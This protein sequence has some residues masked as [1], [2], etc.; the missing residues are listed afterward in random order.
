MFFR[1]HTN[2][3][4]H[5]SDDQVFVPA[6]SIRNFLLQLNHKSS[7]LLKEQRR[8]IYPRIALPVIL[9]ETDHCALHPFATLIIDS[10]EA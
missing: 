9:L 4:N 2:A 10:S 1:D 8:K 5:D 6:Q 7:A 3:K